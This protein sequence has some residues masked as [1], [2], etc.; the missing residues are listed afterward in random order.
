LVYP[1]VVDNFRIYYHYWNFGKDNSHFRL[2]SADFFQER[3]GKTLNEGAGGLPWYPRH[4]WRLVPFH[5]L[6]FLAALGYLVYLALT[7]GLGVLGVPV[8]SVV[9]IGISP[10]IWG[11]VTRSPKSALPNFPSYGAALIVVG[12]AVFMA[13]RSISDDHD[14]WLW[15]GISLVA[16]V[17]CAWNMRAVAKDVWPAKMGNTRMELKLKELGAYEFSTYDTQYN[18]PFLNALPDAVL[19][20]YNIQYISD[21]KEATDGYVGIPPTNAKGSNFQSSVIGYTNDNELDPILSALI[22]SKEI[23]QYAVGCYKTFNS[24]RYWSQNGDIPTYREFFLH[25]VHD[26]DRWKGLGWILDAK[27]L[28]PYLAATAAAS[29]P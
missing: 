2:L 22:E 23:L 17:G 12:Y 14:I 6:Y 21:L 15:A 4:F 3:I 19:D 11:E 1:N 10:I 24:S 28:K 29:S 25:E 7:N 9:L 5:S 27:K 13:N 20:G 26:A 16:S 8:L 18:E